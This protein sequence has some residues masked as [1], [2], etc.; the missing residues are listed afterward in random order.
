MLLIPSSST[1]SRR[2][3][4]TQRSGSIPDDNGASVLQ[5]HRAGTPG[6]SVEN[7]CGDLMLIVTWQRIVYDNWVVIAAVK[8]V[9]Q[10]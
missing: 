4:D 8:N 3:D 6:R 2:T 9:S 1:E 7:D 10:Q 5:L